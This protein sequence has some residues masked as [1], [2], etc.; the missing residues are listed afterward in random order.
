MSRLASWLG[1]GRP[2]AAEPPAGRPAMPQVV[3]QAGPLVKTGPQ[4]PQPIRSKPAKQPAKK[5]AQ[6]PAEPQTHPAFVKRAKAARRATWARFGRWALALGIP[7]VIVVLLVASPVAAVRQGDI[8]IEGLGGAVKADEVAEVL[9]ASVGVPLIRLN[10]NHLA[11]QLEALPAVKQATVSKSWPTGLTVKL[12]PRVAAAAVKDGD[13]Y[14]LLDVDAVQ[15]ERVDQPP[16]GLPLVTVPLEEGSGRTLRSVLGV[17]VSL[18]PELAAQ[19][20]QVG[21]TTQDGV[22]LVFGDVTVVW[23]DNSEAGLKAAAVELLLKDGAKW[24]DVTAPAHPV[25][26]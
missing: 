3:R 15:L 23:G 24:I 11:A 12:V 5:R 1:L 21:A 9:Q 22:E 14:V 6:P 2:P 7:A 25:T 18:P 4:A 8:K 13:Q 10:T 20:T 26:K 16:E 17:V 19:L